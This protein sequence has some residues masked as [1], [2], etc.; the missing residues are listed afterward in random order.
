M[1]RSKNVFF[2]LCLV[3]QF[4][5]GQARVNDLE[6][7]RG[8]E[9]LL[10]DMGVENNFSINVKDLRYGRGRQNVHISNSL[11]HRDDLSDTGKAIWKRRNYCLVQRWSA[12]GE[13]MKNTIPASQMDYPS[14]GIVHKDFNENGETLNAEL[15]DY[16]KK[17]VVQFNFT[18]VASPYIRSIKCRSE[19]EMTFELAKLLLSEHIDLKVEKLTHKSIDRKQVSVDIYVP[20]SRFWGDDCSSHGRA[21]NARK[22]FIRKLNIAKNSLD[23]ENPQLSVMDEDSDISILLSNLTPPM[24]DI[25]GNEMGGLGYNCGDLEK[26][27][28][29]EELEVKHMRRWSMNN[30]GE[31]GEDYDKNGGQCR[32]RFV[33]SCEKEIVLNYASEQNN[34]GVQDPEEQAQSREL[35]REE[36][37]V[38]TSDTR[39]V[40]ITI[41]Q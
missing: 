32:F 38:P 15:S 5:W 9:H 3:S 33:V 22:K 30:V 2:L 20:T 34:S 39:I 17:R 13:F 29:L 25:Y 21:K 12:N 37:A 8:D 28:D 11:S 40:P 31:E 36:V 19:K 6:I 7:D 16:Q 26:E 4:S 27:S 1:Y 24:K 35:E 18:R 10:T 14:A 23:S 41:R